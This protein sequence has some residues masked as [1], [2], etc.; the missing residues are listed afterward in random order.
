MGQ[1]RHKRDTQSYRSLKTYK[2]RVQSFSKTVSN[3]REFVRV[4]IE[5][6]AGSKLTPEEIV[7]KRI[8]TLEKEIAAIRRLVA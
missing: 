7:S 4:Q 1:K 2:E 3:L 6:D 8:Q 5:L